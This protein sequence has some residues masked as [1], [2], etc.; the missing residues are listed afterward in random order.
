MIFILLK[1]I[2]FLFSSFA[3][4]AIGKFD[5]SL[6]SLSSPITVLPGKRFVSKSSSI[7]ISG[8]PGNL[9]QSPGNKNINSPSRYLFHS[10]S[11]L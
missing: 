11:P 4:S 3:S 7:Q 2:A 10:P 9:T 1:S 5:I 6:R 8:F